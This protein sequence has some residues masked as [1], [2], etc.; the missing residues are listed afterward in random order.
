[1]L[2]PYGIAISGQIKRID[3]AKALADTQMV[4]CALLSLEFITPIAVWMAA[5]FRFDDRA[6]DV[7]RAIHD[8]GK[9]GRLGAH[10]HVAAGD[11]GGHAAGAD[12]VHGHH[13]RRVHALQAR[14]RA[15]ALCMVVVIRLISAGRSS[16]LAT[17]LAMSPP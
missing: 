16:G 5:S 4:S 12:P 3:G 13:H 9:L 6:A 10:H 2:V 14:H 7:T 8:I 1:M 17:K 15:T 11:K